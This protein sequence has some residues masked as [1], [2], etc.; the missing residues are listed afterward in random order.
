M[1]D[2]LRMPDHSFGTVP[3]PAI[4]APFEFSMRVEDFKNLGGHMSYV[5]PI[6]EVLRTG[7]WHADG[8]PTARKWVTQTTQNPWPLG[9]PPLLG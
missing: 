1:V 8:A 7:A 5:R 4:V 2:V 6:E 3:T 9:Q